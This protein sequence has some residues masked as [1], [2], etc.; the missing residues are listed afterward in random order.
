MKKNCKKLKED[1]TE[2]K[3]RKT[4]KNSERYKLSGQNHH[5]PLQK[6]D[7]SENFLKKVSPDA[8]KSFARGVCVWKC[9]KSQLLESSNLLY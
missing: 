2:T 7:F 4:T 3:K 5:P 8:P 1:A 9:D 6:F